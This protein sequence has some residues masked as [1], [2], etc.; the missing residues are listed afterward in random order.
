LAQHRGSQFRDA[1]LSPKNDFRAYI[2]FKLIQVLSVVVLW[3]CIE[4][5]CCIY[6][7]IHPRIVTISD[8]NKTE[9]I[10]GDV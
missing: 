7:S 6:E 9:L 1:V 5:F 3:L 4:A 10:R 8:I 2:R